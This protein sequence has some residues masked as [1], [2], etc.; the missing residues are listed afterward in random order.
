M[1]F[2]NFRGTL[3]D[4]FLVGSDSAT[5]A[6]VERFGTDGLASVKSNGDLTD[7]SAAGI[8]IY[9]GP[10]GTPG[11]HVGLKFNGATPFDLIFGSG[12]AP[13][14]TQQLIQVNGSGQVSFVPRETS[15]AEVFMMTSTGGPLNFSEQIIND[16]AN[17]YLA[18][19]WIYIIHN[20]FPSDGIIT[21][22]S[23]GGERFVDS[24]DVRN[25]PNTGRYFYP[26]RPL[27]APSEGADL[28][29][30]VSSTDGLVIAWSL[31]PVDNLGDMASHLGL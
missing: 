23:Y 21:I 25:L 6:G 26:N 28:T 2:S 16:R 18:L 17:D 1:A 12:P 31:T 3:R 14:P 4:R 8:D 27:L 22:D 30:D 10:A 11:A 19:N 15:N 24:V 9:E 13:G 29:M 7:H 5:Q 20:S